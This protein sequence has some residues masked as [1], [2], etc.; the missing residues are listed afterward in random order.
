MKTSLWFIN[1]AALLQAAPEW[2]AVKAFEYYKY[3]GTEKVE[4]A[5][6]IGLP[7]HFYLPAAA[8]N[9]PELLSGVCSTPNGAPP[10]WFD[11]AG[12][13]LG[14]KPK[15]TLPSEYL[16]APAPYGGFQ[17]RAS[18]G[19]VATGSGVLYETAYFHQQRCYAGG[20]E[21][22]FYRNPIADQTVFYISNNSNCGIQPNGYCHVAD[23][24]SSEYV[25]ENNSPGQSL[26]TNINGWGIKNLN[27]DGASA[28]LSSLHY[29]A[30][31]V[32]DSSAPRGFRFQVDVLDPK[33]SRHANCDAYDTSGVIL[34]V[35]KPC[36]FPVRPGSWYRIDELSGGFVTVGI[37]RTGTPTI[38]SPVD[39]AVDEVKVIDLKRSRSNRK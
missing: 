18:F 35:N 4:T 39:F 10:Y 14:G 34:I 7:H 36:G 27:I 16:V 29:S 15:T 13:P 1:L 20:M 19:G 6:K 22:G 26:I 8:S 5:N 2:T 11:F 33:T 30:F 25:N 21:F 9:D 38:S 24:F 28:Q 37:Q 3:S 31:I 23:S 32:A 17:I 12:N